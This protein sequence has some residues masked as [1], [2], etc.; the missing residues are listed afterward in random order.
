MLLAFRELLLLLTLPSSSIITK[1]P[2]SSITLDLPFDS[3][4]I[5]GRILNLF[6]SVIK[7]EYNEEIQKTSITPHKFEND[8]PIE[9]LII[10]NPL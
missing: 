10:E 3:S 5:I 8:T 6:S 9:E 4:Y 2:R 1:F 7:I